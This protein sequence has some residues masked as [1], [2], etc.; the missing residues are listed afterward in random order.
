MNPH[1]HDGFCRPKPREHMKP[2]R[3]L[4]KINLEVF[5]DQELSR[6]SAGGS[7]C[8]TRKTK[9]YRS[10]SASNVSLPSARAWTNSHARRGRPAASRWCRRR[11]RGG[12]RNLAVREAGQGSPPAPTSSRRSK[13][14]FLRTIRPQLASEGI[15]L[16]GPADTSTEQRGYPP[17][18]SGATP[19][20][21]H[22]AAIH[23]GQPF[24][25]L[26]NRSLCLVASIRPTAPSVFPHTTLSV[27]TFPVRECRASSECRILPARICSS[28]SKTCSG[29]TCPR[30]HG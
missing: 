12:R 19:S 10:V 13:R 23:A 11:R 20:R 22:P 17:S 27:I 18:I 5:V 6:L 9:F 30:L 16:I 4:A 8:R 28:C 1:A 26:G 7:Y 2:G 3:T 15:V 14:C 24:P 29:S 21:S 25:Y